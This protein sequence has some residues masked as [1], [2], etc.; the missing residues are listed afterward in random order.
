VLWGDDIPLEHVA[1]AAGTLSYELM[2]AV[3]LRVPKIYRS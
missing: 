2:C 1:D 3:A